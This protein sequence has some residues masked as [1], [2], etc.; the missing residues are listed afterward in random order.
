MNKIVLV[1]LLKNNSIKKLNQSKKIK[2]PEYRANIIKYWNDYWNFIHWLTYNYPKSPSVDNKNQILELTEEMR[3]S[4]LK[5]LE[6]R[7]EF[8]NWLKENNINDSLNSRDKLFKYFFELHNKV[9]KKLGKKIYKLEEV[10]NIYSELRWKK[11]FI[12]NY[13]INILE[14]FVTRKLKTFPSM[15]NLKF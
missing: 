11:F 2:I 5:C 1:K 4:G 6:C 10:K 15:Y 12:K 9:N 7:L 3:I 13:N 8:D 14:L